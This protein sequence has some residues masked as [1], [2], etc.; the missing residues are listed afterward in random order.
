MELQ[1]QTSRKITWVLLALLRVSPTNK[2]AL[3]TAV[4]RHWEQQQNRSGRIQLGL[5]CAW[6]GDLWETEAAAEQSTDKNKKSYKTTGVS[7]TPLPQ[8]HGSADMHLPTRSSQSC[9]SRAT[10]T[11]RH[12]STTHSQYRFTMNSISYWEKNQGFTFIS[13]QAEGWHPQH[14]HLFKTLVDVVRGQV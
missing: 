13:L 8:Q 4:K 11:P 12:L 3:S 7:T 5:L 2:L 9:T 6:L 14:K 10:L 1:S